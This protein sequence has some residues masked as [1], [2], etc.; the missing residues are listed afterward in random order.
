VV[1]AHNN[2]GTAL[3]SKQDLAGAIAAYRR[4]LALDP[5]HARTHYNL[6]LALQEMGEFAQSL[7]AFRTLQKLAAE[8]PDWKSRAAQ[9]VR[10]A[11]QL[12]ELDGKLPKLLQG[13][14]HPTDAKQGLLLRQLC[15]YKAL[16]AAAAR[17]CAEAFAA[18]PQLA[19]NLQAGHR[20]HAACSA[21]L[22]GCGQAKDAPPD[23]KERAALRQQALK[24]LRADLA[25]WFK[26]LAGGKAADRLQVQ[27]TLTHWCSDTD[28]AGVRDDKALGAL[29]EGEQKAWRQ[30][31]ADVAALRKQVQEEK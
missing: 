6:G 7:A 25:L 1:L 19:D 13:S 31:W 2:L 21:A 4:A 10:L 20:Y 3:A 14:E 11:E 30:L 9:Q 22:A 16:H 12:L 27:R 23:A 28:L 15:C 29:P 8:Q 17:F 5:N 18:Q 24:W 26:R